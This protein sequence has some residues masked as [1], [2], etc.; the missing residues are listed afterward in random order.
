MSGPRSQDLLDEALADL[1]REIRERFD[2]RPSGP[3]EG[4]EPKAPDVDVFAIFGE[5]RARTRTLG[6]RERRGELDEFGMDPE[7]IEQLRPALSLLASRWFRVRAEGLAE[8][9]DGPVLFVANRSG[10][11]PWDGLLVAHQLASVRGEAARPRFLVADWL[12]TLPFAQPTLTRLGAVR[13]CRENAEQLL[14]SGRSVVA[15]PEGVKGASKT[16]GERYK[17]Q[18]FGRGGAVRLGLDLGVPIVPVSVVGAEETQPILYK[19]ESLARASGLPFLPITPT[20][21]WLGPL[22]FVP[23]PSRL[24]FAFGHPL[25]VEDSDPRDELVVSRLNEELRSRIQQMVDAGLAARREA[26]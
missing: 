21:P 25:D 20:F 5:L 11:L 3:G 23:L 15:F 12:I 6:M 10:L 7:W 4:E 13:A 17:L 26:G 22:G 9:P 24:D 16:W 18:R 8:V 1:G 14:R 19:V 2:G